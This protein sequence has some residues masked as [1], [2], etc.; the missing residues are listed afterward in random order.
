VAHMCGAHAVSSLEL[1]LAWLAALPASHVTGL[2]SVVCAK[3]GVLGLRT[4]LMRALEAGA[5]AGKGMLASVMQWL[6]HLVSPP[7][8]ALPA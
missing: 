6:P 5:L 7:P 3:L 2:A 8:H 4:W 1:A